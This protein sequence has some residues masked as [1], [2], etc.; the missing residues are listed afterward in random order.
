[1]FQ[2]PHE[3]TGSHDTLIA[4]RRETECHKSVIVLG[5][6]RGGTD[7]NRSRR[8]LPKRLTRHNVNRNFQIGSEDQK[9][10]L[11][12]ESAALTAELRARRDVTL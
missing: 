8:S 10:R 11:N 3:R 5:S 1:M 9:G 6:N 7:Q 12:Y 4:E 2:L